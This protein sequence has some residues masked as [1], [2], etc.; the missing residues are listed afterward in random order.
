MRAQVKGQCSGE[1]IRSAA[2]ARARASSD[3]KCQRSG[4][5]LSRVH[6]VRPE[7][8][9]EV[10]YLTWTDDGLLRKSSMKGCERTSRRITLRARWRRAK[11]SPPVANSTLGRM[12]VM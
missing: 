2:R 6:W 8:V 5:L 7:F 1:Q 12:K 3:G 4:L 11:P 10:T 9:V